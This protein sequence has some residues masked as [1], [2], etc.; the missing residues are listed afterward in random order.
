M[1]VVLVGYGWALFLSGGE[2][3]SWGVVLETSK[4][5]IF[6]LNTWY[7]SFGVVHEWRGKQCFTNKPLMK[8][9]KEHKFLS[10]CDI[11]ITVYFC[12]MSS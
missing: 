11:L 12:L 9:F 10:S 4:R 5:S 8:N 1:I 6:F 7:S 3:S 2:L